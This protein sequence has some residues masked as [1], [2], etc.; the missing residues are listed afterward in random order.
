[1]VEQDKMV[2]VE[3]EKDIG[4]HSHPLQSPT[5]GRLIVSRIILASTNE[6]YLER[7]TTQ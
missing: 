6:V 5:F 7:N 2:F 4:I 1:M 3:M